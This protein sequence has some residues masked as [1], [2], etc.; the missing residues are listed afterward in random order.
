MAGKQIAETTTE[1]AVPAQRLCNEI[2]L[3]DLCDLESC[4]YKNGRFCTNADLLTAFE[5]ISDAEEIRAARFVADED[6]DGA[7][8]AYDD[9]EYDDAL[10]DDERGDEDCCDDDY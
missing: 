5:R 10:D 8:V 9:D 6:E 1:A 7:E 4:H 3:F 2:Q